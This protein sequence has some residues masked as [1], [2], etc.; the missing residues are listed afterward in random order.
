MAST[1]GPQNLPVSDSDNI[2]G[3]DI[4]HPGTAVSMYGLMQERL[5]RSP[6]K[7]AYRQFDD[8]T[9]S[10]QD[11]SWQELNELVSRW[12]TGLA[13]ENLKPGDR[14][15]ICMHNC[16]EWI[17]YEMAAQSLGLVTIS[18]YP[19]DRPDNMAYILEDS[20][21]RIFFIE[22][23]RRWK[24]LVS[25]RKKLPELQT[26]LCLSR[27]SPGDDDERVKLVSDWLP[28]SGAINNLSGTPDSLATIVYT[29]GT[30][31]RPKGVM[32]S[33]YNILWDAWAGLQHVMVYPEDLA[34]SFLPLSHTL[35]RTIG[36]ILPMMA[37]ATVAFNRS[38][39]ELAEDLKTIRPTIIISVPRIF[40][41][42]YMKIDDGLK[43]KPAPVRWLFKAAVRTGW[44]RFEYLQG[45]RKSTGWK[46]SW[47]LYEKLFCHK[48]Q[49]AFGGRLRF[50]ISGG[51]PLS[52]PIAKTFIALGIHIQQGYGLTETSPVISVNA[53]S[54]N[55]P[56]TVGTA[57]C[58]TEVRIGEDQELQVKSPGVMM[59]YWNNHTATYQTIDTDGWLHTGDKAVIDDDG[60]ITITGRLKE[61]IVLNTGEKVPP[62]DIEMAIAADSLFD[63]VMV[64]GEGHPFLSVLVVLNKEQFTRLVSS[65]KS[66]SGKDANSNEAKEYL[67]QRIFPLLHDF[68]G[69]AQI[70]GIAVV[71]EQWS[72][73][74]ELMTPTMKLKRNLILERYSEQIDGIY[75]GHEAL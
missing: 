13:G 68:P 28:D 14:V 42:I 41:R 43:L 58:D 8:E 22:K 9:E 57:F 63:Q 53:L 6:Q 17:A 38:I 10:W 25:T 51:A 48:I 19:N 7:C 47:P 70:F 75:E 56:E 16:V 44:K 55:R 33:H 34:L 50:A 37:G 65:E 11:I 49:E 71:D 32:L 2:K 66:L 59:G 36:F 40:E 24:K 5:L 45:R 20:G 1:E 46:L 30:T 67:L 35:E 72:V 39:P 54:D 4:I 26:V 18:L 52:F 73:D 29:S 62:A 23:Y 27:S 61:I 74:N 64:I 69:Y 21:A 60:H 12:H 15:A 3:S 31:G